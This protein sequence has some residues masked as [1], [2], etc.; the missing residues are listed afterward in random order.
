MK[1]LFKSVRADSIGVWSFWLSVFLFGLVFVGVF[2]VWKAI[3]P[4]LPLYNH[5]P[6]GYQRLGH[7]FEIFF[8]IVCGLGIV[9][10]NIFLASSFR[11]TYPLLARF[12]FIA[13]VGIGFF[14]IV[15]FLRL[16]QIIL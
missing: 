6:W 7:S 13:N 14:T 9:I 2:L 5:M 15:F 8:P 4:F 11:V 3:P 16:L 10:L 1:D 12:L